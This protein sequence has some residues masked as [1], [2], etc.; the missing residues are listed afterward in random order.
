MARV[1]SRLHHRLASRL[2]LKSRARQLLSEDADAALVRAYPQRLNTKSGLCR[3]LISSIRGRPLGQAAGG[4]Y[5]TPVPG[6]G[7]VL[8]ALHTL[9]DLSPA[10]IM[11]FNMIFKLLGNIAINIVDYG[12][13]P[14]HYFYMI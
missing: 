13:N 12:F 4:R 9:S 7:G 2:S 10:Y 3:R 5:H 8:C 14:I 6:V 1:R 11:L